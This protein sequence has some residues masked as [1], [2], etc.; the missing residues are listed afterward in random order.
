MIPAETTEILSFLVVRVG[1]SWL[2]PA[3]DYLNAGPGPLERITFAEGNQIKSIGYLG[4][5]HITEISI[6]STVETLGDSVFDEC[7]YLKTVNW[8]DAKIT[9][10]P[11]EAFRNCSSLDDEVVET[12]PSSVTTIKHDAFY[13]CGADGSQSDEDFGKS[14]FTDLVIPDTV[15]TIE[16]GAFEH[17]P[18]LTSVKIGA[19]VKSI[20]D[21]AFA[22]NPYLTELTLPQNVQVI[23]F[24]PCDSSA[25][26]SIL[27]PDIQFTSYE[28]PSYDEKRDFAVDGKVYYKPFEYGQTIIAYAKKADGSPTMVRQ[29]A[30]WYENVAEDKTYTSSDTGEE[31]PCYTFL[32]LDEEL[33]VTGS[34]PSGAKAFLTQTG[35]TKE[36]EI[37]EDGSFSVN[38]VANAQ[39]SIRV[40]LQGYYDKEFVRSAEEMTSDWDIGT[41][42][43]DAFHEAPVDRSVGITAKYRKGQMKMAMTSLFRLAR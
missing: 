22:A 25:T 15:E 12:L 24:A 7:A 27:N 19:S 16:S 36:I 13:G 8:N 6:P 5:S 31:K 17:C 11:Q 23:G 28:E 2:L 37:N 4:Y 30:D 32:W 26:F 29:F 35:T 38:A 21:G 41:V 20:G 39:A 10:I 18:F 33:K 9:T 14:Y 1:E 3:S 43:L 34:L 40:S 42:A